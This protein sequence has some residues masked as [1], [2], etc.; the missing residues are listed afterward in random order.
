MANMV[1]SALGSNPSDASDAHWP[2]AAAVE[3]EGSR[4][5]AIRYVR[6]KNDTAASIVVEV[7]GELGT[8]QSG[9]AH[10]T[11]HA[12]T[13]NSDGSE[14]VVERVNAPMDQATGGF[15]RLKIFPK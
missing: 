5:F 15:I 11:V 9:P 10:T 3:A 4:H 7:S 13:D 12:V 6:R 14:T 1:E 8:W 2:V